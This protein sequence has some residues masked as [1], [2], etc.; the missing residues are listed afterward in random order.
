ME[1]R[2]AEGRQVEGGVSPNRV[3]V[4]EDFIIAQAPGS[5]TL[6]IPY[7]YSR[8]LTLDLGPDCGQEPFS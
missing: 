4:W 5:L 1:V 3:M 7:P 2:N 8:G 6:S